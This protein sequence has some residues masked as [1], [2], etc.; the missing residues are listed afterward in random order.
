MSNSFRPIANRRLVLQLSKRAL[1]G[2]PVQRVIEQEIPVIQDDRFPHIQ[3]DPAGQVGLD[4]RNQQYS[5]SPRAPSG[6]GFS[7]SVV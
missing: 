1:I 2:Q 4:E 5:R 6:P 3:T 7:G